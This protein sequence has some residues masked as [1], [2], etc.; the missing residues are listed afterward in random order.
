MSTQSRFG[1]TAVSRLSMLHAAQKSRCFYCQ[2]TLRLR[3]PR[4]PASTD[5]ATIDHF[6]PKSEGGLDN[7]SNWIL[8]CRACNNRKASRQPTQQEMLAWNQLAS[9][10]QFIRPID[11]AFVQKKRCAACHCWI[12]PMRLGESIK[13]GSE[14]KTCRSRCGR[15]GWRRTELAREMEQVRQTQMKL[16]ATESYSIK[17]WFGRLLNLVRQHFSF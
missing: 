11:L 3:L 10:W 13:A 7:W 14:T 9:V 5:D 6:F 4:E 16:A 12:S 15:K 1:R 2:Q 17:S 8:A